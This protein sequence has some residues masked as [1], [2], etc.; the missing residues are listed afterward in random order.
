MGNSNFQSAS[1]RRGE[2]VADL[3]IVV[4]NCG[5]ESRRARAMRGDHQIL[6]TLSNRNTIKV[7]LAFNPWGE[8]EEPGP[9]R[10]ILPLHVFLLGEEHLPSNVSSLFLSDSM[11]KYV[12]WKLCWVDL[13][14]FV[15]NSSKAPDSLQCRCWS[16]RGTNLESGSHETMPNNI[17]VLNQRKEC[18]GYPSVVVFIIDPADFYRGC[19]SFNTLE[20]VCAKSKFLQGGR[21]HGS[22]YWLVEESTKRKLL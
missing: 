20:E 10:A 5:S 16:I 11:K 12:G 3:S 9:Q 15:G 4:S 7:C 18:L 21:P 14:N 19:N 17:P 2:S 13:A 6:R 8:H 22:L 1:S